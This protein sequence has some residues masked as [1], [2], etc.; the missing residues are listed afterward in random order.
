M[1]VEDNR[2]TWYSIQPAVEWQTSAGSLLRPSVTVGLTHYLNHPSSGSTA[3]LAGSPSGIA[4]F[5][6]RTTCSRKPMTRWRA[7]SRR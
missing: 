3:V 5:E 7:A 4:G 2:A 1:Q 6:T